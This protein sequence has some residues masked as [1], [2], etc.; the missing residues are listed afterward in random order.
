MP[1]DADALNYPYI[2]IENIDWLK[3][4]L[5]L[6][7]HVLRITP[8]DDVPT[9]SEELIEFREA[10]GRRG[11]LLQRADVYSRDV[12]EA[13]RQLI[14]ALT[15][16]L[17]EDPKGFISRFGRPAA[18]RAAD[19]AG[20]RRIYPAKLLGDLSHYLRESRLAWPSASGDPTYFELHPV[21]GEA[22]MATIALS[23]AQEN[24]LSLV[25]EFPEAHSHV[26]GLKSE[27]ILPT[28]FDGKPATHNRDLADEAAQFIV[29]QRCNPERLTVRALA[30]LSH[31]RD[32]LLDF[33]AAL[34]R[35]VSGV[36]AGMTNSRRRE[37]YLRDVASDVERNWR[38]E[39]ANMS[40]HV[41]AM[42]G[43]KALQEPGKLLSQ[44]AEK[45]AT[46][47]AAGTA[48]GLVGTL[49]MGGLVGATA[50]FA[51]AM[52]TYSVESTLAVRKGARESRFR[53]LTMM[54]KSGVSFYVGR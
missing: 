2:E 29:F 25:T 6:F 20:S 31:E 35:A 15:Q 10:V 5:L 14:A 43:G 23:C 30:A 37:Q 46:P 32:A 41:R 33:R 48:S 28:L 17:N 26:L 24:G 39:Q 13:Q 22:V 7:P 54:E 8:F 4:T 19:L 52:L 44:I 9:D 21:L 1:V 42:F 18:R 47:A 34:E 16:R 45:A 12:Y 53:Y 11:P 36:P 40:S 3:R 38:R 51:I 49:T 27:E 50:G